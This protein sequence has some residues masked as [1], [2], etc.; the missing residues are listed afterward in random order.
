VQVAANINIPQV[1]GAPMTFK[2]YIL[3]SDGE[4]E[5]IIGSDQLE[6]LTGKEWVTPIG[7]FILGRE[8]SFHIQTIE[9]SNEIDEDISEKPEDGEMTVDFKD[10]H[11]IARLPL[12]S[13]PPRNNFHAALKLLENSQTKLTNKGL[14]E[15]YEQELKKVV[16]ESYATPTSDAT[17]YFMPHHAV[18]RP[19]AESSQ[20]RIV[21]NGSFGSYSLNKA[22][23]KGVAR[24]LN[25][26]EKLLH[27]RKERY[28][29]VADISKAFLQIKLHKSDQR[30]VK[31]LW[32]TRQG[33]IEMFQFNS[34][35]FGLVSSPAILTKCLEV[36]IENMSQQTRT[37]F[38]NA[39]YMDDVLLTAKSKHDLS[40]ALLEGSTCFKAA[41]FTLHKVYANFLL[42]TALKQQRHPTHKVLGLIW[43]I[44]SDSFSLKP[45]DATLP[46]FTRNGLL[47]LLGSIY[48]PLGFVDP[49]KLQLKS[50]L[51]IPTDQCFTEEIRSLI[52]TFCDSLPSLFHLRWPRHCA[53]QTLYG[54]CDASQSAYGFC[55]YLHDTVTNNMSF[56]YGRS[57][58]VPAK[59]NRTIPELELLSLYALLKALPDITKFYDIE[60]IRIFSDSM[61]NLQRLQHPPNH[62]K[63]FVSSKLFSIQRLATQY[64]MQFYHIRSASNPADIFSRCIS[65]SDFVQIKNLYNRPA[66]PIS[67][68]VK[69][70]QIFSLQLHPVPL[71]PIDLSPLVSDS[72]MASINR[73]RTFIRA[74]RKFR[75]RV[76]PFIEPTFNDCFRLFIA[77]QQS[78]PSSKKPPPHAIMKDQVLMIPT[79]IR[80]LHLV[81]IPP[82]SS[83]LAQ[84]VAHIHQTLFHAGTDRT[85]SEFKAKYF[86]PGVRKTVKNCIAHCKF[87][88]HLRKRAICQPMGL[89]PPERSR[90]LRAFEHI[91][92]DHFGPLTLRNQTK[93]WGLI[94]VCFAIRAVK[95][96]VVTTLNAPGTQMAL[97]N[98]FCATGRPLTIFSDNGTSFRRLGKETGIAWKFGPPHA[99]WWNATAERFIGTVKRAL[100]CISS[101]FRSLTEVRSFF[102]HVETIINSRTLFFDGETAVTPLMLWQNRIPRAVFEEAPPSLAPSASWKR[103][104]QECDSLRRRWTR[105]YLPSLTVSNSSQKATPLKIGDVVLLPDSSKHRRHWKKAIIAKL[106]PGP[107]G[108]IRMVEVK[109]SPQG[110]LLRRPANGLILLETNGPAQIVVHNKPV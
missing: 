21:F 86:S 24:G 11:F 67:E 34:L 30:F 13:Q 41:G 98:I 73:F 5:F 42:P 37:L 44:D 31:F 29:A 22:L 32:K 52:Q 84:L 57:K 7:T 79:R 43:H 61:I 72:F 69:V 39:L 104:Q 50:F 18:L 33:Q 23:Y 49:I 92:I 35:P 110:D 19:D 4:N 78:L 60:D 70:A 97:E 95:L 100:E 17:G 59:L 107:D 83:L 89:L 8:K 105:H 63:S 3:R 2:A 65:I 9:T 16:D 46:A 109:S 99:P 48:D 26:A 12:S 88:N 27:F 38:T 68:P 47:S 55:L 94:S 108:I 54:F 10:D 20:F 28:A 90:F 62:F 93:F 81:Y 101:N 77:S 58:I 1:T 80:D 91:S 74:A 96:E 85:V 106:F 40:S 66:P 6:M 64:N 53:G 56:I 25:V 71:V 14:F 15:Q 102:L 75:R 36:I 103:L 87:C 45:F 51:S 76:V 82:Q